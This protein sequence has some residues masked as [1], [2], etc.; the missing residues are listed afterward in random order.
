MQN[1][2][3]ILAELD[4]LILSTPRTHKIAQGV[5]VTR[6]FVLGTP[7][8]TQVWVDDAGFLHIH[9]RFAYLGHDWGVNKRRIDKWWSEVFGG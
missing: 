8:I 2:Q 3:Y 1:P 9:A 6:S 7:D 5:Y 4:S